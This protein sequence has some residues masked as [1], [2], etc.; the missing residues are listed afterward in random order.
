MC[1]ARELRGP[2]GPVCW[3]RELEFPGRG[4]ETFRLGSES[5]T[6]VCMAADRMPGVLQAG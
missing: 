6:V 4:L 5:W 2:R 1:L 3:T